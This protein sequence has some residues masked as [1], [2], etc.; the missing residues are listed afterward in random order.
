MKPALLTFDIFGTV[1]DWRAG[2]LRDAPSLRA[3]AD[4][5]LDVARSLGLTTVFVERP[6]ARRGPA[7]RVVKDLVALAAL[8]ERLG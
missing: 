8:V 7:E 2:V 3:Y 1:L 4:D 5:D 6:H